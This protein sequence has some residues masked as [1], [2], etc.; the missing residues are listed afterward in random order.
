M[1]SWCFDSV[2]TEVDGVTT[3][4]REYGSAEFREVMR[5]L[6]GDGVYAD[7]ANNMQVTA[8]GGLSVSVLPGYCWIK[9]ALGIVDEAET[10][11]LDATTR[12]RVDLIVA[13]FDLSLAARDIH[14]VVV[15]G[16]EG[17]TVAPTLTRNDSVYEICLARVQ[18]SATVTNITPANITD[19]RHDAA[20]CGIVTGVI[21]QIDTTNLFAQYESAFNGFMQQ[22]ETV[23]SGDVAGN[24]LVLIDNHKENTNN[25]HNVTREQ[26]GFGESGVSTRLWGG[27]RDFSFGALVPKFII[28]T[29][30]RYNQSGGS[31]SAETD[32]PADYHTVVIS[33]YVRFSF[34]FDG[35]TVD[36]AYDMS[37]A[38]KLTTN[39]SNHNTDAIYMAIDCV[40]VY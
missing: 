22:L 18:V 38:P 5:K 23:L 31:S 9:G 33:P 17:S 30:T 21:D 10:L 34:D 13:R 24:L 36:L 20:V 32:T 19:T 26:L 14:L 25:P 4:D 11:T 8:S 35:L 40:Y 3:Y 27:K 29:V 7:P 28:A 16:T 2:A 6:V 39:T 15:K 1:R 37:N 12:N